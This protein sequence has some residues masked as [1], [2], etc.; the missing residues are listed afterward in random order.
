VSLDQYPFASRRRV[1]LADNGVVATSQPLAA[2]A[3]LSVLRAGGNAIDAAIAAAATLTVVEPT[4][5]GIGGD[6][7]ALVWHDG[8]LSAL[9]GSGR[10][11]ARADPARSRAA[12]AS[13]LPE[14]GWPGVTVPGLPDAWGA[15]HERFARLE[16]EALLRPAIAYARSGFPVSPVVAHYWQRAE[17]RYSAPDPA[18]AAW[19]PTFAPRGAPRAGQRVQLP[20]HAT[21]LERFAAH[22]VRDFYSGMI[23]ERIARHASETG[24][25]L[26]ADDLAAHQSEWVEPIGLDYR[27]HRIWQVPPNCPGVAALLALGVLEGCSLGAARHGSADEWHLQI[28]ALKLALERIQSEL[29]DPRHVPVPVGEWLAP[30]AL[31]ERRALVGERARLPARGDILGGGT[32][33][34]CTA[35][36][37]GNMV[38]Y[39]QSNYMGFGSGVVVPELGIALHNRGNC[40]SLVPGHPNEARPGKRPR[41]TI[42]P[43]FVTRAG[44]A[45]GPFGVMGG[46]MQPQ[47]HV[48]LLSSLLDHGLNVQAALDAPRFRVLGGLDVLVE[49]EVEPAVI[50]SLRHRGHVV[51]VSHE[52]GGFGRG[53]IIQRL[54]HGVF[55]AGTEPRADGGVA[56]W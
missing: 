10:L 53:Q 44:Q 8:A 25:W 42:M 24:G 31:A 47:G 14:L 34:L 45:V 9:N 3:G 13:A 36:R 35:D 56:A 54:E 52:A 17:A 16:L 51:Q 48:Q 40:F 11:P 20:G 1:V 15:L 26:G 33:Y 49:P 46:D 32:V 30:A 55:A 2:E 18:L 41:H 28:E 6:A 4:S 39:I 38:S 21:T 43:G 5:N 22:G 23:A 27:G 37:D 7:F 50:D 12:G 29:C 19:R